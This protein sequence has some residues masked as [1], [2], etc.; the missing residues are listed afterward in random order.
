MTLQMYQ[1]F[2]VKTNKQMVQKKSDDVTKAKFVKS[3]G[4][5]EY[6]E[7]KMKS[8]LTKN[9]PASANRPFAQ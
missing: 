3:W 9:Q 4:W 2:K 5:L 6:P 8:P 1:F 7:N